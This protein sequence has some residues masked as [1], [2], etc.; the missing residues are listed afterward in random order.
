MTVHKGPGSGPKYFEIPA[1]KG[2]C[3]CKTTGPTLRCVA[4]SLYCSQGSYAG[5]HQLRIWPHS[6]Y[7]QILVQSLFSFVILCPSPWYLSSYNSSEA[8]GYPSI[9]LKSLRAYPAVSETSSWP[10]RSSSL[11]LDQPVNRAGSLPRL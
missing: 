1:Q 8:L 3:P 11:L 7:L 5:L 9:I 6:Y 10:I 4:V 2:Q